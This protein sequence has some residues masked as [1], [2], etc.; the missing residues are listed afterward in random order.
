MTT[1]EAPRRHARRQWLVA[2]FVGA[3]A[4]LAALGVGAVELWR[5][6]QPNAPLFSAPFVYSIA[7]A[8]DAGDVQR[9]Y[10]FIRMGQD[11]NE[12]VAVRDAM[13]TGGRLQLVPP[14][15][16]AIAKQR[17]DAVLML[18]AFRAR[19]DDTA[20]CV[21]DAVGNAEIVDV[22]KRFGNAAPAAGRG[23]DKNAS[24]CFTR[25]GVKGT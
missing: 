14:L 1:L 5:M 16:W 21:A 10:E 8:I 3:P 17:T 13:L 20:A 25:G 15:I 22:L 9:A 7:D 2:A 18:L 24:A 12:P 4:V 6:R 11:P 19:A 23:Y